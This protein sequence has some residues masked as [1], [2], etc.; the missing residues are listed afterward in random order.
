MWQN[1]EL[2][3]VRPEGAVLW[4]RHFTATIAAECDIY[5]ILDIRYVLSKVLGPSY[6]SQLKTIIENQ[7][8]PTWPNRFDFSNMPFDTQVSATCTAGVC[9]AAV[10]CMLTAACP[11]P[12]S[13]PSSSRVMRWITESSGWFGMNRGLVRAAQPLRHGTHSVS[14]V[15]FLV[16]RC[17]CRD[18]QP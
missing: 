15:N 4:S 1:G 14:Q 12:R 17:G 6:L 5:S 18:D 10:A 13:S 16:C 3:E 2:F 7:L 11:R 8:I 9:A